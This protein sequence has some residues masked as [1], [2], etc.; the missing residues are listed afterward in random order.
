MVTKS[1]IIA[2]SKLK[3]KKYRASE[4]QFI[5]EGKRL[6]AEGIGSNY[7]CN[8]ILLTEEF[9][10]KN[11]EYYRFL[12]SASCNISEVTKKD[13]SK[14]SSTKS[15]QGIAAVF[16]RPEL[17]EYN[18]SEKRIVCL[19]NI[20]DPGNMGTILRSCDWFG[21]NTIFLSE[22]CADLYN[23]KVLRASMGAVFHLD[24]YENIDLLILHSKLKSNGYN[25]FIADMDGEDYRE[26]NY[27]SKISI[28]FCNEAFGPSESLKKVCDNRV[29][30]PK[31]GRVDS[32]N[33]AAAAAIILAKTVD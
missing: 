22:D 3:L 15:P 19:E 1:E 24:I 30:I 18:F 32:L 20:S 23:P 31:A 6:V 14:L 11:N 28:T 21:I 12:K 13:F 8:Q 17:P 5:A 2:L 25:L 9:K 16:A 4:K 26:I 33:V 7:K 27:S 29:T 10:E